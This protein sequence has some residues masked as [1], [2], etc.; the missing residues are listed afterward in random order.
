MTTKRKVPPGRT[1]Y[2]VRDPGEDVYEL[3]PYPCKPSPDSQG[4]YNNNRS[5][6]LHELFLHCTDVVGG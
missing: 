4:I 2:L 5:H 1:Y 3:W 6:V